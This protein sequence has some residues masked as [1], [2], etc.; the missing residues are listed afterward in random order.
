MQSIY[1]E[2]EI[3]PKEPDQDKAQRNAVVKERGSADKS[4][5]KIGL[6]VQVET[7]IWV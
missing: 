3:T 7:I 1:V 6:C 5:T 4:S 2:S